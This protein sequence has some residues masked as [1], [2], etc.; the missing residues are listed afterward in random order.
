MLT[1]RFLLIFHSEL[2]DQWRCFDAAHLPAFRSGRVEDLPAALRAAP[3]QVMRWMLG[4][5]EI[6]GDLIP[7]P[8]RSNHGVGRDGVISVYALD[9]KQAVI[10]LEN[11]YLGAWLEMFLHENRPLGYI[12]A[13]KARVL[14]TA[15]VM[16]PLEERAARPLHSDDAAC[17]QTVDR[18]TEHQHSLDELR[19]LDIEGPN[20]LRERA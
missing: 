17:R 13:R 1:M 12:A 10:G 7:V 11:E 15:D 18:I 3:A 4:R 6:S 14:P 5:Y 16:T 8:E 2:S 19:N 20:H 9:P